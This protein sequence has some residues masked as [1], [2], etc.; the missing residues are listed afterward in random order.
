MNLRVPAE[1]NLWTCS[2]SQAAP[3]NHH[4]STL[5]IYSILVTSLFKEKCIPGKR[6][7]HDA[8][9]CIRLIPLSPTGQGENKAW[10]EQWLPQPH[11]VSCPQCLP[12]GSSTAKRR[13][14]LETAVSPN[15][16]Q[17]AGSH[18]PAQWDQLPQGCAL[19]PTVSVP[20]RGATHCPGAA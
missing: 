9:F 13:H 14:S 12:P 10:L 19:S 6:E 16:S 15:F 20:H 17:T 3:L 8:L 2:C 5:R 18:P 11:Q 7:G 1:Q 4:Q